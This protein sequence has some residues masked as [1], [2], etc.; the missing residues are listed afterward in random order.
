M[1]VKNKDIT[2]TIFS[3]LLECEL[4]NIAYINLPISFGSVGA[5]VGGMQI[6]HAF[7]HFSFASLLSQ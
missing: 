3:T 7:L 1:I 6:P 2:L 4:K 5:I